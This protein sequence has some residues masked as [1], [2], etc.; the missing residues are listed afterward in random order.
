[1]LQH[2]TGELQWLL[3]H[4]WHTRIHATHPHCA[5]RCVP[6]C[7]IKNHRLHSSVVYTGMTLLVSVGLDWHSRRNLFFPVVFSSEMHQSSFLS[8]QL[9]A[10]N[11]QTLGLS[12][13]INTYLWRN[14]EECSGFSALHASSYSTI[15]KNSFLSEHCINIFCSSLHLFSA[16]TTHLTVTHP[17]DRSLEFHIPS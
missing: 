1:M 10:K 15:G 9:T 6:S 17:H 4:S 2:R 5:T 16:V 14:P 8:E 13:A 7:T 12:G 11:P 3:V